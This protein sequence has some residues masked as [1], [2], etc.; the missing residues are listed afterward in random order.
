MRVESATDDALIDALVKAARKMV[1]DNTGR[2]LITQTWNYYLDFFPVRSYRG[3]EP[4]WDGVRQVAIS[5]AFFIT[6]HI[7]LPWASPLI[8]ITH[9]KT[10]DE[11]DVGT[12]FPASNFFAD[13]N[14]EPGR[15]T[16][17]SG[18][19]WPSGIFR[20][21]SGIEIQFVSGYGAAADVPEDIKLAIKMTV[22]WLY[23][24]RG[25]QV[26]KM[27]TAVDAKLPNAVVFLLNSYIMNR[28]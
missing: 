20:Q 27:G 16:L 5:Q 6:Q 9:L 15:L 23:E 11:N 21:S 7:P 2:S 22:A 14:Q 25:D 10:F 18:S 28:L 4:W 3:R 12:I 17:R 26:L 24:H 8:S 1:E 19:S 13:I